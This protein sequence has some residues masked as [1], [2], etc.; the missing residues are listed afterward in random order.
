MKSLRSVGLA[1]RSSTDYGVLLSQSCLG[2]FAYC[3]TV[4]C[5]HSFCARYFYAQLTLYEQQSRH[6]VMYIVRCPAGRGTF[7]ALLQNLYGFLPDVNT[8][9]N[10]G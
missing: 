1:M 4:H 7:A 2:W 9:A 8:A 10:F 6:D 5:L 3:L